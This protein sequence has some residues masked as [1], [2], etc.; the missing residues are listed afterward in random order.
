MKPWKHVTVPLNGKPEDV[1]AK[2]NTWGE[3][4]WE[5]VAIYEHHY[6]EISQMLAVFKKPEEDIERLA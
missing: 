2:F 1:D 4:G 5:L 3:R 6:G